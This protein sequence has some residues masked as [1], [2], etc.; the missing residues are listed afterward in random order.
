MRPG[1]GLVDHR[2]HR[3]GQHDA[4]AELD[5]VRDRRPARARG[6]HHLPMAARPALNASETMSRNPKPR[7]IPKDSKRARSRPH[8]PSASWPL[9]RPPDPIERIL[10]FGEDGCRAD[11]EKGQPEDRRD[12]AVGR[13]AFSAVE[14]TLHRRCP[15]CPEQT[16]K[17][18]EDFPVD[19]GIAEHEAGD[20]DHDQQQRR[21]REH[22]VEGQGGPHALRVVVYPVHR[23]GFEQI[24]DVLE[25]HDDVTGF[26]AGA[27]GPVPSMA[28]RKAPIPGQH[29]GNRRRIPEPRN[30]EVRGR[31]DWGPPIG[32]G[33]V[34]TI[35]AGRKVPEAH[36]AILRDA[37]GV[38]S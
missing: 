16:L 22:R 32:I 5:R 38:R 29:E 24:G 26:A 20:R 1:H 35:R 37:I 31:R 8:R 17:L 30:D 21:D 10:Q 3:G 28:V 18:G 19:G 11:E 13:S 23:S 14:Q 15:G 2:E 25:D 12:R 9:R 36:L 6:S 27:V 7:I 33:T 34:P 4:Q